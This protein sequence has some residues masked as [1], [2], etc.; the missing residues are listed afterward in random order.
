MKQREMEENE[1]VEWG[2]MDLFAGCRKFKEDNIY[3]EERQQMLNDGTLD[4]AYLA[5][6]RE[7]GLKKVSIYNEFILCF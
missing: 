4:H 3:Q 5:L 2:S 1:D 7:P 6:S